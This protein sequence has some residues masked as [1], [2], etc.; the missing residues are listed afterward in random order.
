MI[1]EDTEKRSQAKPME[2]KDKVLFLRYAVPC[3]Q[4][5]VKRGWMKQK[6][7]D[8]LR[9]QA[10]EGDVKA[11]NK[12]LHAAFAEASLMLERTANS[13]GKSVI[14][15]QVIRHYFLS[16]VHAKLAE[17]RSAEFK[18]FSPEECKVWAGRIMRLRGLS[19][20]VELPCGRRE[21]R[22]DF[23]QGAKEGDVV[24]VHYSYACEKI[25]GSLAESINKN[26]PNDDWADQY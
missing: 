14:D 18:D 16:H 21:I 17:K 5:L 7:L 4:V 9:K 15:E 24:T 11:S 10:A 13:E 25:S 23:V 8:S 19:A 6:D 22:M 2:I 20:L 26:S 3:G 12:D 1:A